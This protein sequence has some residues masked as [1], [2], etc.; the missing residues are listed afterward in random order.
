[1]KPEILSVEKIRQIVNDNY[2]D[3]SW[4]CAEDAV[5]DAIQEQCKKTL[6]QVIVVA[7]DYFTLT[8]REW[9]RKYKTGK[10]RQSGEELIQ[11][12][13][14]QLDDEEYAGRQQE[15]FASLAKEREET[16]GGD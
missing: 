16:E 11:A 2:D 13:K 10:G 12:L 15:Y 4:E 9:N 5:R 8:F 6:E 3:D 14:S 1:M 7:Q